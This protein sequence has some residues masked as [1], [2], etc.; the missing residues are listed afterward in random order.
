MFRIA[1]CLLLLTL[2]APCALADRGRPLLDAVLERR[3]S[4]D[5]EMARQIWEWAEVGFR[6]EQTSALLQQEL[7]A[8]GF[9]I[10]RG[11][12]GMPTAFVASYGRG[13]PVIGILAEMDAL[14]GLSQDAVPERSPLRG[15][16]SGH[17]CGHN[18][19]GTAS[20]SAAIAVKEWLAQRGRQ[21]TVRLYGTPAEEGGAGKVY[22][23]RSGLFDDVDAV[24]H[25]HASDRNS[26]AQQPSL[27]NRS[28]KFRFR[29]VSSHASAAPERGRSS[30]DGVEAMNFM[31]NLMREHVPADARIHYVITQGGRAP[32]VVPDFGEVYYYVRHENPLVL[33]AIFARVVKAAEGAAA[34][35]GTGMDY[36]II[37]GAHSTLPND[38]LGRLMDANL[39]EVGGVSYTAGELA[40]AERIAATL[41]ETELAIGSQESVL[42]YEEWKKTRGSTDVGDV[43]WVVP[44]AGVR[45]ATWVPGTASHSWQAAAAGGMSIGFKGMHVASRTL[46]RTA[47]DL[48]RE[49]GHIAAARREFEERRG[50]D[51]VYRPLLGDRQPALDYRR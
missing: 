33:E 20:T 15:R 21:G 1:T 38:T 9:G 22:L 34:G 40:F 35:T 4:R 42:P 3:A 26:A 45:V 28:A 30:L 11:V 37:H 13:R 32:N 43:S 18:L 24:L 48:Y 10:E 2:A 17:A 47:I 50:P 27:A 51:F 14:P 12:A 29:G 7:A 23:V 25:W 39:R 31:V 44:T 19:F 36:E 41:G 5:A 49:P 46:A 6:E 8:A 16:L